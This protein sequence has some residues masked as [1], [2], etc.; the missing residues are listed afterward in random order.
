MDS[1]QK[2]DLVILAPVCDVNLKLWVGVVVREKCVWYRDFAHVVSAEQ[3]FYQDFYFGG[4]GCRNGK[5]E[6]TCFKQ[7]YW[8]GETYHLEED[9]KFN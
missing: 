8:R 9:V 4:C 3:G 6:M 2:V 1:P 7:A 5:K